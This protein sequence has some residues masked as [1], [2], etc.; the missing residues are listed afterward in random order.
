MHVARSGYSSTRRSFHI[1][2]ETEAQPVAHA[3]YCL[4]DR[5][6]Y[7][8]IRSGER[9]L[10]LLCCIPGGLGVLADEGPLK[11]AVASSGSR[12]ST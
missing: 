9:L 1:F 2:K 6:E 8:D 4:W 3:D 12:S 7:S 10:L 5:V 11:L